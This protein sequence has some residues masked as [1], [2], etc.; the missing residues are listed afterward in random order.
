M[1]NSYLIIE[2]N[3]AGGVNTLNFKLN[4][5]DLV[6]TTVAGKTGAQNSLDF[7]NFVIS[8]SDSKYSAVRSSFVANIYRVDVRAYEDSMFYNFS[9]V[10]T[11]DDASVTMWINWV[12]DSEVP[13]ECTLLLGTVT[14]TNE[15]GEGLND[16][17]ANASASGQFGEAFY[18][19]DGVTYDETLPITGLAPGDYTLYVRD[20]NDCTDSEPFTILPF[21][22]PDPVEPGECFNPTLIISELNPYRFVLK[23]CNTADDVERLYS[24]SELCGVYQPC[25]FQPLLC[26]DLFTLQIQYLDEEF[27][28]IPVLKIVEAFTQDVLYTLPFTDLGSGIYKIEKNVNELP[29]ICGIKVYLEIKS[30]SSF[31]DNEYYVHAKSEGI[32]VSNYHDCNLLLEYW[33]DSDYNDT[34]YEETGYINNLRLEAICDEEEMPQE[35]EV[36]QKSN[37]E[38]VHLSETIKE[39]WRLEVGHAP[40]YLHKIIALAL[41]HQHVRINGRE[42]VKEEPYSFDRI[43]DYALRKGIGKLSAKSYQ[44]K[45]LIY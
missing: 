7:Y 11:N 41:S 25:Y 24:E 3:N 33:N 2:F 1:T 9:P 34:Y 38:L 44:S 21:D 27:D 26:D 14:V 8:N 43:K 22:V 19:L 31:F 37:G 42:Y 12:S 32:Y 20:E 15:T 23:H 30:Y 36:Y 17:T 10:L 40:F 16:G 45:N 6:F 35:I 28:T 39:V 18:S 5:V 13:A 4:G 29:D